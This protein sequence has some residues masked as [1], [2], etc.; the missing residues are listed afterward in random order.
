MMNAP[1]TL[2]WSVGFVAWQ[3]MAEHQAIGTALSQNDA[4]LL[5]EDELAGLE[6]ELDELLLSDAAAGTTIAE[7]TSAACSDA[8]LANVASPERSSSGHQPTDSVCS[9][10]GVAPLAA[11]APGKT[12]V[13]V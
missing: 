5:D 7:T 2:S 4:M 10:P 3:E 11:P 8:P 9:K 6:S 1:F 12:A 13:P